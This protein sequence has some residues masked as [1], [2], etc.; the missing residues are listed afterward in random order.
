MP[1]LFLPCLCLIVC[2]CVCVRVYRCIRQLIDRKDTCDRGFR[3]G[4]ELDWGGRYL[5]RVSSG[6]VFPYVQC[7]RV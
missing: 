4:A 1:H 7:A 5:F 3:A 6:W 2:V